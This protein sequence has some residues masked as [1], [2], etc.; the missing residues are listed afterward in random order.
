M[1]SS[2]LGAVCA[3]TLAVLPLYAQAQQ[4]D[5]SSTRDAYVR[6]VLAANPAVESARQ[7][8]RAALAR[9]RQAGAFE[10]PMLEFSMAPLSIGSS[11]ARFGYEIGI[12]QELPWFGKRGL[13]RAVMEA[14]AAAAS[15][16]LEALRRELAM[17]ALVLYDQYYVAFRSLA[18]NAQHAELVRSMREAAA[19]QL[20]TGRGS[21]RD[22]LAAEAELT[23]LEREAAML[24]ADRDV[25][26]AQM[27]ELLHRD[28][29]SPLAAPSLPPAREPAP[30]LQRA[31]QLQENALAGRAE[32]ESMRRRA[33]AEAAKAELAG[34][35]Y[36]PTFNLSTSYSSMWDMA[37][38]RWMIGLGVSVPLPTENRAAAIDEAHAARAQY[39]SE[40]ARMSDMAKTQVYVTLRRVHESERVLSLFETRLVPLAHQQVEAAQSGFVA[41][42]TPFSAVIEA[43]RNLR[44]VEL[45][46]QRAQAEHSRRYAELERALGHLPGIGAEEKAP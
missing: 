18:I 15:S 8:W 14:E 5:S 31:K 30:E 43:E 1:S 33:R 6:A 45:D 44:G 40:I 17:T 13:E 34:S 39:E 36:Y 27:N 4:A 20:E 35:E 23:Q 42:Q 22:V 3:A 26:A 41:S 7:G 24:E 38:H 2:T 11:H 32:I 21:A 9:A 29:A 10:D 25:A 19:A 16:D 46:Q 28:P 12:Q 37:P